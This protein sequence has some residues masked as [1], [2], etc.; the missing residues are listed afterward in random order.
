MKRLSSYPYH[1]A[2]LLSF[3]SA[4]YS[5]TDN[6]EYVASLTS[7][8][9]ISITSDDTH[10]Q[11]E[12]ASTESPDAT[13]KQPSITDYF[14]HVLTAGLIKTSETYHIDELNAHIYSPEEGCTFSS[15]VRNNSDGIID[16]FKRGIM[17]IQ[18]TISISAGAI[19]TSDETN[20]TIRYKRAL[21]KFV[22]HQDEL[23]E[24]PN[25]SC[26]Q[27]T[28]SNGNTTVVFTFVMPLQEFLALKEE[29]KNSNP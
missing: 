22:D 18:P 21:L 20:P 2:L 5:A 13:K 6:L 26:T 16:R 28:D 23:A 25:I 10:T 1:I 17:A 4:S 29:Y 11:K 3:T 24:N 14:K 12:A 27:K 7:N 15:T 9:D 19:F 8:A